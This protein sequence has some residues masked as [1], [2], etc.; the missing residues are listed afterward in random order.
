VGLGFAVA[1]DKPGGFVGREALLARRAAGVPRRRLVQVL[2]T[3][4]EPLLH[5]GEIILRDGRPVGEV[6]A[7]SYGWTLGGAVGLAMVGSDGPVTREWLD[8]GEWTVDIAGRRWPAT[9]SLR[10]MYDPTSARVTG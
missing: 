1:V 7:G 6:R 8:A 2:L 3:D 10:P 4:A 5:H 9:V